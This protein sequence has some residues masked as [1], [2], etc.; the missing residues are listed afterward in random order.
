MRDGLNA[1]KE[2]ARKEKIL[3]RDGDLR[4]N[5]NDRRN[6][7]IPLEDGTSRQLME[8]LAALKKVTDRLV[9]K[10]EGAD[11]DSDEEDKKPYVRHI[12]DTVLP[13]GFKMPSLTAYTGNT[14][15]RD[16]LSRYNW[17]MTVAR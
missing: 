12:L 13:K 11:T 1:R 17:L 6:E 10:Q 7:R 15:P 9:R 8:Q 2:R 3:P 4:N 5:I 14:D 16:H